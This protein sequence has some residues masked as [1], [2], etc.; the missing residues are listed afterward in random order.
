[1]KS[2]FVIGLFLLALVTTSYAED[3]WVFITSSNQDDAYMKTTSIKI[4]NDLY[5]SIDAWVKYEDLSSKSYEV[6]RTQ[7]YCKSDSFKKMESHKYDKDGNYISGLTRSADTQNVI[8]DTIAVDLLEAA[9]VSAALSELIKF[10][11]TD[12][13]DITDQHYKEIINRFGEYSLPAM[14]YY[15]E[16]TEN[17]N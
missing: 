5:K 3:D 2:K 4:N 15:N 17:T 10:H 6:A 7:Y 9:C 11:Y 1:M 13:A 14:L 8:P 12:D 16:Q